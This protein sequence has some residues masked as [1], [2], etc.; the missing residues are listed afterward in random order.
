[1]TV[2][3]GFFAWNVET[4]V[5][6]LIQQHIISNVGTCLEILFCDRWWNVSPCTTM[7]CFFRIFLG[8][9]KRS[10]T[11]SQ[12]WPFDPLLYRVI[13]LYFKYDETMK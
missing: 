11:T 2:F 4:R 9:L 6:V 5:W 13:F 7:V 3:H 12:D 10:Q 8:D 1:M